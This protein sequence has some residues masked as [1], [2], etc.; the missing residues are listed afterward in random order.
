MHN[1][2]DASGYARC[3]EKARMSASICKLYSPNRHVLNSGF[4][5]FPIVR[6]G[7]SKNALVSRECLDTQSQQRMF[8]IMQHDSQL[9]PH[10]GGGESSKV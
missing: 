6:N 8:P 10:T 1:H 2:I 3:E 9:V 5:R 4:Q 7:L